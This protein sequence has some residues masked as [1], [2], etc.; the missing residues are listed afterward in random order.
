[1]KSRALDV[2]LPLDEPETRLAGRVAAALGRSSTPEF[3][4]VRRSLDARRSRIG[5]WYHVRLG[6]APPP[7]PAPE[8]VVRRG[9]PSVAIV[10][11]GPAGAFCALRLVRSGIVPVILERGRA[12]QP[13]RRDI[14]A[15]LQRGDLVPD[16]N[17]CFGEGGAGTFSDGKLYTRTKDKRAVEE[18]LRTLCEFGAPAE[19]LVDARPHVGSNR[20]PVVLTRLRE[21]LEAHGCEYRF[22]A[23]VD[24]LRLSG[25]AVTGVRLHGGDEIACQALVLATGHSARD[26]YDLLLARGVAMEPK[27]F[28]IGLRVEQPQPLIDRIQYGRHAGHER[29]P[30]AAYTITA[31]S[32]ER[33]VYSFCMC[34]GGFVVNSSTEP[35]G[36]ATNG[37]SLARR[38]SRWANAG[39]VVSLDP[40]EFA[41]AGGGALAGV[42]IQ[43]RC[44][45]SAFELG[46][47]SFAAPAQRVTDFLAGRA[48]RDLPA[49]SFRPRPVAADLAATLPAPIVAALR[50]GVRRF[51]ERMR[52]FVTEEA[53]LLGVETRTS[54]PVRVARDP[55]T[56]V[57]PT[58]PGL[59]P[60]GEGAGHAGGIVSAAIDGLR[61]AARIAAR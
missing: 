2:F 27:P 16:S 12:V 3:H 24:D 18:V 8:I 9:G 23:R 26:V 40:R 52:G 41:T 20:L 30:P 31:T 33:S 15:L 36:V 32:G 37:M 53:I 61:V 7:P 39:L 45:R 29:L 50:E 25:A 60:C 57:S 46:G 43:R 1:V 11:S 22:G 14:A 19:I 48:S 44:E 6:P 35:G 47:S 21:Y 49:S 34:P 5:F 51:E 59:Y 28:A 4:V 42:E 38:A 10:G 54:A 13:R 17:Y 56:L 58:H 55:G